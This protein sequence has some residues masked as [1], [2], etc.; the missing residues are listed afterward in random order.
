MESGQWWVSLLSLSIL[1]YPLWICN[2][3]PP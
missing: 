1:H 2:H 3:C